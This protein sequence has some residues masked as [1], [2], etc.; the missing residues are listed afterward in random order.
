MDAVGTRQSPYV[1]LDRYPF[2]LSI[3]FIPHLLQALCAVFHLPHKWY[4][5]DLEPLP[6]LI[7][8]NV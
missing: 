4:S 1:D 3:D 7:F 5:M 2:I 8:F 6:E